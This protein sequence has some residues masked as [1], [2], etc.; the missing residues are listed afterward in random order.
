MYYRSIFFSTVTFLGLKLSISRAWEFIII[1]VQHVPW[2]VNSIWCP[3]AKRKPWWDT[4]NF[5]FELAT[6]PAM[7]L[8]TGRL[9]CQVI[10]IGLRRVASGLLDL[11]ILWDYNFPKTMWNVNLLGD[12]YIF[13]SLSLGPEICQTFPLLLLQHLCCL[14]LWGQLLHNN[15]LLVLPLELLHVDWVHLLWSHV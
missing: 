3:I 8:L 13:P 5:F 2:L 12:L 4:G 1:S 9:D 6:K 11:T 15:C 7:D 10:T 14:G